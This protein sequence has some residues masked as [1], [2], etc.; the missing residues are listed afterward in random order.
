MALGGALAALDWGGH[1]TYVP[2]A[3]SALAVILFVPK[4]PLPRPLAW[5]VVT[6]AQAS[7]TIYLTHLIVINLMELRLG[8]VAPWITLVLA[9][10]FGVSVWFLQ[11]ALIGRY[12]G[13]RGPAL[14]KRDPQLVTP[15]P[16]PS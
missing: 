15:A 11:E 3:V 16:P 9:L 13:R 2:W 8:V 14:R 7:F 10:A 6:V 12:R 5:P 4:L 1:S